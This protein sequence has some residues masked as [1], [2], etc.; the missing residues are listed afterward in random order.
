[1]F[2]NIRFTARNTLFLLL[3]FGVIVKTGSKHVN[4]CLIFPQNT[5]KRKNLPRAVFCITFGEITSLDHKVL[6]DPVEGGSFV[7]K[8]FPSRLA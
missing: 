7:M 8:G 6:D 1:M 4:T 5:V 2:R 3:L